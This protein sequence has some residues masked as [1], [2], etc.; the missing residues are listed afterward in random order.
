MGIKGPQGAPGPDGPVGK[1]GVDGHKVRASIFFIIFIK[2][3]I[4]LLGYLIV[5][6]I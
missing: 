3:Q 6:S 1:D 4:Q 5:L 2:Y